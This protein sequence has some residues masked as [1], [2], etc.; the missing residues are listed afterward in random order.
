MTPSTWEKRVEAIQEIMLWLVII[1]TAITILAFI[2]FDAVAGTGIMFFLTRGNLLVSIGI[3]LS[4][5]GLLNVLMLLTY[6]MN[7]SKTTN[8]SKIFLVIAGLFYVIDIVLD[9]LTADVLAYGT[10]VTNEQMIVPWLHWTYRVLIGGLSSFGDALGFA[11]IL[12]LTTLKDIF[13]DIIPKNKSTNQGRPF[14]KPYGKNPTYS[15]K[16]RV[17]E[18]FDPQILDTLK[19][20]RENTD[21]TRR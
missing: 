16:K 3:S 13:K 4:T 2:F 19:R 11:T 6:V 20:N 14:S 17:P 21:V 8:I 5:S 7:K 10:V 12:G 9:S 15:P 18:G 1:F